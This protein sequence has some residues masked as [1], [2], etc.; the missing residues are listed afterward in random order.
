M[1]FTFISSV[2]LQILKFSNFVPKLGKRFL[3]MTPLEPVSKFIC[4]QSS[5]FRADYIVKVIAY[6][7]A[8]DGMEKKNLTILSP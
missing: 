7:P 5:I 1:F 6:H 8:K 2:G 3:K 4:P